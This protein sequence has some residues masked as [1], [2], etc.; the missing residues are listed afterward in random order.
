MINI[1]VTSI[2]PIPQGTRILNQPAKVHQNEGITLSENR[3]ADIQTDRHTDRHI[4]AYENN[5]YPKCSVLSQVIFSKS[6]FKIHFNLLVYLDSW[7]FKKLQLKTLKDLNQSLIHLS[8]VTKSSI[9]MCPLFHGCP[10]LRSH[11]ALA[12]SHPARSPGR[13][14]TA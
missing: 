12:R 5:T 7:S 3:L 11:V 6:L 9:Y 14:T 8:S 1:S 10:L 4:Q 2:D 13:P